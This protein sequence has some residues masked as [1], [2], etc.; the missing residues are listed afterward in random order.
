MEDPSK[1][2]EIN[3]YEGDLRRNIIKIRNSYL[4]VTVILVSFSKEFFDLI[5]EIHKKY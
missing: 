5:V 4:D 1:E 3:W 2:A